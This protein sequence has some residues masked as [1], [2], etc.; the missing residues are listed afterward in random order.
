MNDLTIYTDG[1]S[2]GNPGE[3]AAA[4]L[5]LRGCEVL[6]SEVRVLGV[7]TNNTAEY[8]AL[9]GALA[10]AEKYGDPASI[11]LV[12]FSDSELMIS[13][14]N[15]RYAVRSTTLKPLYERAVQAASS[16][17]EVACVHVPRENAYIG[18]CDWLCNNALDT[19]AAAK[20]AAEQKKQEKTVE[21]RPIGIVHS[22]FK[23]RKDAPNQGKN[24][25]KLST[26]E[27]YPEFAEGLLGLDAGDAVFILCWLDRSERDILQMIPHGSNK[28]LTGV[29]ATRAPVRPNPISLTLVTIVSL[30]G[31]R[32]IVRGLEA[33]DETPVL[34]IKP[35]YDGLDV[36]E[37]LR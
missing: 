23:E 20:I 13:Q 26:I 28:K 17:A 35:Y 36:P 32:I 7:Q 1:A 16:Y 4:W 19:L 9:L 11:R 30:N 24:T 31:T 21:C 25:D 6:E 2:R 29:F 8:T 37:K 33:L 3:A 27:V 5:I 22:P 14:M 12:V 10:A 34:D 15:G 18:S